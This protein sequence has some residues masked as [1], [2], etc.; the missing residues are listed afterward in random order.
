MKNLNTDIEFKYLIINEA[1]KRFGITENTVGFQTFR[2]ND[3]YPAK[4]HPAD[5]YFDE[6]SGRIL[7]EFQFVYI[8]K[9]CGEFMNELTKKQ[10]IE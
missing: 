1:D 8:T 6:N 2:P 5:H 9:G 7:N 3:T 10:I 4:E